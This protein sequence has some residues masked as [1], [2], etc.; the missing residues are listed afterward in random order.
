[1][2]GTYRGSERIRSIGGAAEQVTCGFEGEMGVGLRGKKRG[3]EWRKEGRHMLL[4]MR[5]A[6]GATPTTLIA[7]KSMQDL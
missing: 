3:F 4:R 5:V 6:A 1:M 2:A 7:A